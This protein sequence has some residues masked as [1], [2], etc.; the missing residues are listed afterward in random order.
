M[1]LIKEAE[2]L[3]KENEATVGIANVDHIN[4]QYEH[5]LNMTEDD[6]DGLNKAGC[7][8]VQYC[9]TQYAI[10]INKRLNWLKGTLSINK[11]IYNRALAE[12]WDSYSEGFM[13]L[14]LKAAYADN[15]YPYIKNMHDEILKLNVVIDSMDGIVER[16]DRMIQIIRDLSFTKGKI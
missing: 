13:T 8:A 16:V 15:E 4:S 9:L 2:A 6:I 14:D 3:I 7:I 11:A 12:V 5:Y 1:N 10:S